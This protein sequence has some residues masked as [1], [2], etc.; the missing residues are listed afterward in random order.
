MK[1]GWLRGVCGVFLW[2]C[3]FFARG[4]EG[5]LELADQSV[6]VKD[7]LY[8]KVALLEKP[9]EFLAEWKQSGQLP[10]VE[11]RTTFQRGDIV[12][13]AVMYSTNAVDSEGRADITYT[14]LFRRP[15]GSIYEHMK[16]L[17][18]IKGVPPKGVGLGQ[19]QGGLKIEEGDPE[20]EY[21]LKVTVTDN[22]KNVT[23]EM[24]FHFQVAGA[25]GG[26]LVQEEPVSRRDWEKRVRSTLRD[27]P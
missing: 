16:D 5:L 2:V 13:P 7:G 24:L 22:L 6:Y 10:A 4:E 25:K 19:A 23:V 17:T 15:D 26:T 11:T 27:T 3:L 9:R 1:A 18:V 12:F 21:T 20:G 8:L 14:L